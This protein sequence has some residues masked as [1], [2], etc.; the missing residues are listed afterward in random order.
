MIQ[1][2]IISTPDALSPFTRE[3]EQVEVAQGTRIREVLPEGWGFGA[4]ETLVFVGGTRVEDW[5]QELERGDIVHFVG[6]VT[7]PITI[8]LVAIAVVSAV[9]AVSMMPEIPTN[10]PAPNPDGSSAYGYYG[11]QNSFRAEGDPIP[12]VYGQMRVAPP[13]INQTIVSNSI[14]PVLS[15]ATREDMFCLMAISE[16]P[17][18]GVGIYEGVVESKEDQDA[19]VGVLGNAVKGSGLQINGIPGV[20]FFSRINWRT[21]TLNQQAFN[22]SQ[23]YINY[24]QTS[25]SYNTDAKPLNGQLNPID[26][27]DFPPGSYPNGSGS[28]LSNTNENEYVDQN[29]AVESDSAVVQVIFERGLYSQ[30]TSGG[31]DN[32]TKTIRIQ[33]RRTDSSGVGTG[34]WVLMPAYKV[35]SS[36]TTPQLV[37]IPFEFVS[38]DSFTAPTA[39][40]GYM[41][42]DSDISYY[43][44]NLNAVGNT[45]RRV[46]NPNSATQ[47]WTM[48]CWFNPRD[49]TGTDGTNHWLFYMD[50]GALTAPIGT[51]FYGPNP[52]NLNSADRFMV[53]SIKVDTGN[54]KGQG[55]DAV[56]A[57]LELKNAA[58]G[59]DRFL[60]W[61]AFIGRSADFEPTTG[62]PAGK[63]THITF[64][65]DG[66][67]VGGPQCRVFING[68]L[69]YSMA[70][71]SVGLTGATPA[72]CF[73]DWPVTRHT[74]GIFAQETG[75]SYEES[76]CNW[77]EWFLY[78]GLLDDGT[79][80]LIGNEFLGQD[81]FGHKTNGIRQVLA[82]DPNTL[83]L[84]TMDELELNSGT[85]R[86]CYRDW[87]NNPVG[88]VGIVFGSMEMPVTA[89]HKT[90]G[91]PV[92][93][94]F[95]G[96][97]VK[98]FYKVQVFVSQ[99]TQSNTESNV[100]TISS[101]TGFSSQPF[102]Y[103]ATAI[104][105]VN[106]EADEQVNNQQPS[107]TFLVKG[108]LVDQWEGAVDS[109]GTPALVQGWTRNPAWI[110]A[111]LLTSERY[112]LG[113]ELTSD[114]IDWPSFLSWAQFCDEGV[115]DAFGDVTIFGIRAEGDAVVAGEQLV[116][117]YVGLTPFVSAPTSS[118]PQSW[119]LPNSEGESQAFVSITA[120]TDGGLAP[121]WIT[122]NDVVG[123]Q[124]DASN[125]LGIYSI[126][127]EEDTS[128]FHGYTSYAVVKLRWNRLDASGDAV[129]PQGISQGYEVFSDTL[130]GGDSTL[131]T[132][133]GYEA[134]CMFDGVFDQVDQGGWEAV[135]QVFAAGRAM[136]I[137]AGRKIIASVDRIKPVVGVF[138]QGNIIDGTLELSYTGP[139]QRP[140]SVEGDILDEASNYERRTISVDHSSIQDPTSGDAF[141]KERAEFRGVVRRSQAMRD[142]TYRLNRYFLTRRHVKF[143]VGPDAVNL[144]PGDRIL[145]SHDVPQYGFSG[146]VRADQ[147]TLNSY[148]QAG[149]LYSS[150]DKQGGTNALTSGGFLFVNAAAGT[151]VD[152]NYNATLMRSFP[153]T[154]LVDGPAAQEGLSGS[155]AS[156]TNLPQWATQ[157]VATGSNLYPPNLTFGPLAQIDAT[158]YEC[159]FAVY[160]KENDKGTTEHVRLNIY[161]F[162]NADGTLIDQSYLADF[163]WSGGAITVANFSSGI[164]ATATSIGSGWY[165]LGVV[166]S[167]SV[168][169]GAVGDYLQAR[170][171]MGTSTGGAT[172]GTF[173]SVAEGG[174]GTNF[175]EYG[176]PLDI[177]QSNWTQYNEG[178]SGVTIGNLAPTSEPGP[179]Y[180]T[181]GGYG[182]VGRL[183]KN[184][185]IAFGA[186]PPNIV[187]GHTLT[188]GSAVSSWN[189]ETITV[190]GYARVGSGNGASNT[191]LYV[192]LRTAATVDGDNK[193]NGDG[194]RQIFTT[195]A[196]GGSWAVS[197]AFK[198]EVSGTVNSNSATVAAVRHSST[199][200]DA[201]WVEFSVSMAYTP[202]SGNLTD[203][204]LGIF[205]DSGGAASG[206]DT[207][208]NIWGLRL[209]GQSSSNVSVNPY[210]HKSLNL[211]AAQ[212]AT[213]DEIPTFGGGASI[214]LDRDVTLEAGKEYEVLLRSS[215]EPN[216]MTNSDNSEV[217]TVDASEV[218][219]T[220]S[221]IK[222][223]G[224]ALKISLP[225]KFVVHEGD[226]YSFGES[227]KT[228]EDFVIQRISLDPSTLHRTIEADEYNAAIYNDTE[229]GTTGL[230]TVSS[231]PSNEGQALAASQSGVGISTA[232]ALPNSS[233]TMEVSE[234][235]VTDEMG[236]FVPRVR[237]R[238]S[239]PR[240]IRT[241]RS[242]NL[243]F[244]DASLDA[245]RFGATQAPTFLANVQSKAGEYE[246]DH[247]T[248]QR[249]KRYHIIM[250]PVGSNGSA[251]SLL[252]SPRRAISLRKVPRPFTL[253]P[254]GVS[255]VTRGWQQLY[256]L[257]RITNVRTIEVVEGRIGGWKLGSPAFVIDPDVSNTAS[258][259]TLVGQLSTTTGRTQTRVF[260]R[261]RS[262]GGHYGQAS[263]VTGTEQLADLDYT[264]SSS[265]EN[266]YASKGAISF[267]MEVN[268]GDLH[269]KPSSTALSAQYAPNEINLGSAQR[270]LVNCVAEAIQVRPETLADMEYRLDDEYIRRWSFEGPMDDLDDDDAEIQIDWKWTSAASFTTETYR[271]FRP[272]E[273][274]ARRI[275]F[276]LTFVRPTAS[277]D[278]R[279][280]RCV[281]QALLP[282][283]F[284]PADVD[285]GSFA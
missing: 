76:R 121:A 275:A 183:F 56:Y 62:S 52:F 261:S 18:Y 279:M 185:S 99:Q 193:L 109:N 41:L 38:P 30:N 63:W 205:T 154:A 281:V 108:K 195:S 97:A 239:W 14:A 139:K 101:I 187:Q 27:G 273:V 17:I 25:V 156:N 216:L 148:P 44:R 270:V 164:T 272:G 128:G 10:A 120:V 116:R 137:K 93:D 82:D 94:G 177:E 243:Y 40:N 90:S 113:S 226:L 254:P 50:D 24:D 182:R 262:T 238:W 79:I 285:G 235:E 215:F 111:D 196:G 60:R 23:G 251:M 127:Y 140:N 265:T 237:V 81:I 160:V 257:T 212:F 118:I 236:N 203:I 42:G 219:A 134:R 135:L 51:Y 184:G 168:A 84:I 142:A 136:P 145:V 158:D 234:D 57:C 240:G 92:W 123:G 217:V 146:R 230:E 218:P 39:S 15:L 233:F 207:D 225:G 170:V 268:A 186:T 214:Q 131:A 70:H 269:F 143:D 49:V 132:T 162:V 85:G 133:S 282:P 231:I 204:Y 274:Y 223:A 241:P 232:G 198:T 11:F 114:A 228:S 7:D 110:A 171:Y 199:T 222:S 197:S 181:A 45:Y 206:G 115:P 221:T 176:D 264:D 16:G 2:T 263:V 163:T 213:K 259:S 255:T 224:S 284:A 100:A 66:S 167:N 153:T 26:D 256:E 190:S 267:D 283:N 252:A 48:G 8:V 258:D 1:I 172:S 246:F 247:P 65:Y 280:S 73:P 47:Q 107:I 13:I 89:A 144:L 242:V 173:K 67:A 33:Y 78:D 208:M 179:F 77:C 200:N 138:G 201:N 31:F 21:G 55:S 64:R 105:S 6:G 59:A 169:G 227:S 98:S 29:I 202:T 80:N 266:D 188:T 165:R 209:H 276:R 22:G 250:Q 119:R 91:A 130:I 20:N 36:S 96:D 278:I 129:W 9:V 53:A 69:S 253:V 61:Y 229:F 159:A 46:S 248:L 220:G 178:V 87:I 68:I 191:S 174:R 157:I 260:C 189:G 194:V 86:N 104:A 102:R 54:Q 71:E 37:D 211:T 72:T 166:Y 83:S 210:Y 152:T 150:W 124:N 58:T 106:V 74:I 126:A 112:G 5:D 35:S 244:K 147:V 32:E 28:L 12:I 3:I 43:L 34:D 277:Y 192:D 125:Q 249:G 95:G 161:R 122:K 103:P 271:K 151:P 180:S 155:D 117:L 175:L 19:L 88:T 149:D 141:R 4:G 245:A 75:G